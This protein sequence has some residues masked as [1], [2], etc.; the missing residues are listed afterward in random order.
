MGEPTYS[1]M[2]VRIETEALSILISELI[3]REYQ[4]IGPRLIDDAILYDRISRPEDLPIGWT[5][6][7][8]AGHYRVKRRDDSAFFGF[9]IGPHSWKK[10]LH[11]AQHLLWNCLLYT[12]PSPRD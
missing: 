5:D 2:Q 4:V 12:S 7:Q 11:P 3:K 1:V 8:E 9:V 6:E 10:Y